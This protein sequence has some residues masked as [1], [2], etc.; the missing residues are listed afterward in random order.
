LIV[1]GVGLLVLLFSTAKRNG[2]RLFLWI[3]WM[4]V[5]SFALYI[6]VIL[7]A[8]Q[9]PMIGMLMIPKTCAYLA[10]AIIAYNGLWKPKRSV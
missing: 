7:F 3:S 4:I 9:Y 10:V 5:L 2:D 1:Q 8:Q 6:P